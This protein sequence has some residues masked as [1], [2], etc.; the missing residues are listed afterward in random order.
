MAK[1]WI[2]IFQKKMLQSIFFKN[3]LQQKALQFGH[4]FETNCNIFSY[5]F[6]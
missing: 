5:L 2:F 1:G 4:I 6:P 3:G